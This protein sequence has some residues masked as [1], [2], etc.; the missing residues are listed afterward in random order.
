M[1]KKMKKT[2]SLLVFG[3]FVI[4]VQIMAQSK[5]FI[6]YDKVAW[7][8]SVAA[9]RQEYSIEESIAIVVDD[10]E[11][12]IVYLNQENVSDSISKRQFIFN[13]DKLYR[14][15]IT[16]KN[17][18]DA[19][20]SQLKG[21]LEQRYGASTGIDFQSGNRGN[22]FVSIPYNDT[23]TIFGKFAPEI[24]VQLIQRKYGYSTG[25]S[26]DIYV[27]YTWKKFRDEYQASKLGL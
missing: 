27:Y 11:P 23:I 6:G 25:F 13:G 9:V 26:P 10:E 20:Q 22:I 3:L 24:E 1:A 5:L 21:L 8:V 7:G 17:G 19:T 18:S 16:Y 12:N 4:S 14:V 15:V 2:F